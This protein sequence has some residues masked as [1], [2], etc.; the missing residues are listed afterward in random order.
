[1]SFNPIPEIHSIKENNIDIWLCQSDSQ[2]S[3]LDYFYSILCNEEKKRA[4]RFKFDEHKNRF[5]VFH[6][7]LRDVLAKYLTLDAK[8]IQYIKGEKGKPYLSN[9]ESPS[10]QF[11]LS[12]TRDVAILAIT[13][14]GEVG[15]DIESI[16]RKTDWQGIVK[17][18]FTVQEQ[19]ALFA[20]E[21]EEQRQAFYELWT[22]K[23]AYMKVLG[24]G[25]SLS[26]TEFTLSVPPEKP[27]LIDHH[28]EKYQTEKLIH[29]EQLVLPDQLNNF[30]ATIA[31]EFPTQRL[32]YYHY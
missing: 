32:N 26:P 16:D 13:K 1:M 17:R 30:S 10:L 15:V 7:F 29:F 14:K 9:S 8:D 12:H 11:N 18:F 27:A 25:L 2:Q 31:S 4:D 28:C 5:I 24:T 19:R 23:E 6:G 21:K 20:L 22:R 3:K